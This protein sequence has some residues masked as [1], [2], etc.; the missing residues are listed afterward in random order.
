MSQDTEAVTQIHIGCVLRTT[1]ARGRAITPRH[2]VSITI[3]DNTGDRTWFCSP[4]HAGEIAQHIES[5]ASQARRRNVELEASRQ[6]APR[7]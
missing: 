5:W 2:E 3:S 4:D 1:D 7:A 6:Q